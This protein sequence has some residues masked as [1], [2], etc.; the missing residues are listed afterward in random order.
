MGKAEPPRSWGK[1]RCLAVAVLLLLMLVPASA[2]AA[3]PVPSPATWKQAPV[4][5]DVSGAVRVRLVIG[6]NRGRRLGLRA[7]V[8]AKLGDSNTE[9][10]PAFYGLACRSPKG[11]PRS[12]VP[13]I[14]RY[15]RVLLPN[16]QAVGPCRPWTS[17]SRRSAATQSATP[18]SWLTMKAGDMQDSGLIH[19][20]PECGMDETPLSCELRITRPRYALVMTGTNDIGMD[21][22][23]RHPQ[24]SQIVKRLTPV[25]RGIRLRG[26]VPVLSTAPP[27]LVDDHRLQKFMDDAIE[28]IN[29]GIATV[30]ETMNV[31]LVNLWRAMRQPQMVNQGMSPDGLHLGVFDIDGPPALLA[32]DGKVFGRSV[33]FTR[34][35]LRHGANRRN[36]IMLR[37][38]ARLDRAAGSR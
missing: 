14:E 12:L 26:T 15:N 9:M 3:T 34:E 21:I 13:V 8:F 23:F 17:F 33:A 6:V 29:A 35:A 31:P 37:T 30:A 4:I 11:L 32:G 20:P 36:L 38:L 25:V 5:P 16:P 19:R 10:S 24:G 22:H 7:G 27:A 18:S 2:P 28:R 1:G